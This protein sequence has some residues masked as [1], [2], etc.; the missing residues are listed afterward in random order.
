MFEQ[1]DEDVVNERGGKRA[2]FVVRYI[3]KSYRGIIPQGTCLS[4]PA[5]MSSPP[6][7]PKKK[8]S[9]RLSRWLK[10][11]KRVAGA[12]AASSPS[13][14]VSSS[15]SQDLT[16]ATGHVVGTGSTITPEA[17]GNPHWPDKNS[18]IL[19][20]IER[21]STGTFVPIGSPSFAGVRSAHVASPQGAYLNPIEP[22]KPDQLPRF[23]SLVQ[24]R[25]TQAAGF[26]RSQCVVVSDWRCHT[27]R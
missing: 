14:L 10:P 17:S 18:T 15:P 4:S 8:L 21:Y 25:D 7:L 9:Q 19:P 13:I 27:C 2:N 22:S 20:I 11:S 24:P 6:P 26:S 16:H 5:I 1:G 23:Y 3:P 12:S